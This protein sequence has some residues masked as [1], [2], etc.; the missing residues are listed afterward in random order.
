[1]AD[2]KQ[3]AKWM[4]QGKKVRRKGWRNP[5]AGYF[6][7]DSEGSIFAYGAATEYELAPWKITQLVTLLADDWEIA[8]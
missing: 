3:A 7:A 1:M 2:I 4:E 8:E 6:L 5:K